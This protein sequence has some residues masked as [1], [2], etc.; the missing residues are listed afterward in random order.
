MSWDPNSGIVFSG[1]TDSS[2][3]LF[4]VIDRQTDRQTLV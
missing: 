4:N 3:E 2:G 1:L